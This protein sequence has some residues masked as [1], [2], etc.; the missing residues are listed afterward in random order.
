MINIS[1]DNFA[2][3]TFM[4]EEDILSDFTCMLCYGIALQPVKCKKC[5][6][7]Y[8]S[9]CLSDDAHD[10]SIK[11]KYPQQKYTCYKKCGCSEVCQLS[12]IERN[13]LKNLRFNC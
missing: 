7:V 12:R 5:E 3:V 11:V 2:G 8:C 10:N 6:T 1:E 4:T 9:G 13:F